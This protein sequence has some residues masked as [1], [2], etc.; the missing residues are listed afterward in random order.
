MEWV[1][2]MNRKEMFN[3][4]LKDTEGKYIPAEF[5]ESRLDS[6]NK[7]LDMSKNK[8]NIIADIDKFILSEIQSQLNKKKYTKINVLCGGGVDSNYL[9]ILLAKNFQSIEIGAV[10]GL[11]K[12]NYIDLKST[13]AICDKYNL[14]YKEHS[15]SKS[16]LEQSLIDFYEVNKRLPNDVAAPIINVLIKK[17]KSVDEDVL[18]V[19]GQYADTVL[20]ANPQN[21]FFRLTEKISLI[22]FN[23]QSSYFKNKIHKLNFYLKLMLS[24]KESKIRSLCRLNNSPEINKYLLKSLKQFNAE[25]VLQAVFFKILIEYREKDKYLLSDNVFSPFYSDELLLHSYKV[26]TSLFSLYNKK[27]HLR[28]FV[29][30]NCPE[31]YKYMKSRTFESE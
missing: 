10:C 3:N 16:E 2:K 8:V 22:E 26:N 23:T 31:A 5:T 24:N 15:I 17:A 28:E 21:T 7:L 12:S 29:K 14:N 9:L 25:L 11:T 27:K 13:R 6:V 1:D 20:F 30:T 19:D 18:I 4:F